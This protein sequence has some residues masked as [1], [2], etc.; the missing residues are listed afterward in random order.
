MKSDV[1]VQIRFDYGL[2]DLLPS[3]VSPVT[4]RGSCFLSLG[5]TFKGPAQETLHTPPHAGNGIHPSLTK[6]TIYQSY[7]TTK[8]NNSQGYTS[9]APARPT[10]GLGSLILQPNT[11]TG[12]GPSL[13][14]ATPNHNPHNAASPPPPPAGLRTPSRQPDHTPPLP[15]PN[16]PGGPPP[17]LIPQPTTPTKMPQPPTTLPSPRTILNALL[18]RIATIPLPPAPPSSSSG[19]SNPLSLTPPSHRHLIITLHV[20]FPTLMLPALDLLDRRLVARVILDDGLSYRPR[21]HPDATHGGG[22][23]AEFYL[24]SSSVAPAPPRRQGE[25]GIAAQAVQA[26]GRFYIV[27]VGTWHCTCAG[28]AFAMAGGRREEEGRDDDAGEGME[29]GVG[30]GGVSVD[31]PGE[32]TPVCKHLLA[33]LLAERWEGMRGYVRERRVGREE[34]GGLV[35]D[36]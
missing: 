33:C 34:M 4:F 25:D 32:G 14:P 19:P 23:E 13:R 20:L 18:S 30:F 16:H 29:E 31:G 9:C 17:Y 21:H 3:S 26:V 6:H 5:R 27:R 15:S 8:D 35:A 28:F 11:P 10:Q 22:K 7:T 1:G 24:V 36:I 2:S 12:T